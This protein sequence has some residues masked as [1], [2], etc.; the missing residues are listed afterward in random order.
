[1][2]KIIQTLVKKKKNSYKTNLGKSH[3]SFSIS[4]FLSRHYTKNMIQLDS[5]NKK[6]SLTFD[7]V[8]YTDRNIFLTGKA[9]TGKTTFL[10]NLAQ[11]TYKR[12]VIVA[13]TGV[14][15]INA[16]GVTIHSF[17]Q[18][19]F[20]PLIPETDG[21][22]IIAKP[23]DE[24]EARGLSARLQ[25]FRSEKIKLIKSIDLLVIDEIS[26]VRA[27]LLDAV[28][29]VLRR[30]RNKNKPFGGVQL[31]MI[32]DI[33]QLAPIAK[34]DEWDLLKDY[35]D[36]VYFFNSLALKKTSY[37]CIELD[38]IYRQQDT[39]FIDLLNKI[40]TNNVDSKCLDA[41]NS[42]YIPD[43]SPKDS[44][45][46][47]VLTTHHFQADL[48]NKKKHSQIKN[49]NHT[50]EA[51]IS[52][53][54]PEMSYPTKK[55]L[56]L[57]VGAQVMFVKNDPSSLKLFYNGKIGKIVDIDMDE[58]I[59]VKCGD[60]TIEVGPLDWQNCRY[61]LDEQTQEIKEEVIGEFTQYPLQLAWAITIH[62]SQGL[63]FEKVIIDANMAFAPG[64][65][66]VALSRCTSLEGL[67]LHSRLNNNAIKKDFSIENFSNAYH[68]Y[69]P[70]KTVLDRSK[71]DYELSI[72]KELFNFDSFN[73]YIRQLIKI[74][75]NNQNI[76][77]DGLATTLV[78]MKNKLE[79]EISVIGI[80]F[81]NQIFSLHKIEIPI[82]QNDILQE[83]IKK[84]S[85]YF[86]EK[87]DDILTVHKLHLIT[88]NSQVNASIIKI[89]NSYNEDLRVKKACIKICE[90]G[91]SVKN[92][93]HTKAI[94]LASTKKEQVSKRQKKQLVSSDY[95]SEL[96]QK[97]IYWRNCKAQDLGISPTK[98]ATP[99]SLVLIAD[100]LP[101]TKKELSEIA[102]FGKTRVA[103]HGDE[104]LAIVCDFLKIEP[105]KSENKEKTKEL[106]AS[107]AK[108]RQLYL[109]GLPIEEIAQTRN[110]SIST[111]EN[112]IAQIV[113]LGSLNARDIVPKKKFN[114]ISEYF[115]DV[116]DPRLGAAK[117]VLGDS[118][119]YFE[120]K[121]VL[122]QLLRENKMDENN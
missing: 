19:P 100:K 18:L 31:L 75:D 118:I 61:K 35:Y 110:V 33:H 116:Q 102:G 38:H 62:K 112:Y 44:E 67:V 24:T 21:K 25:Q 9:G 74:I 104:I 68:Q 93:L 81:Y 20:G 119:S 56:Q 37:I 28:D 95:E 50:F 64:Q 109:E 43:F 103:H 84:S 57:K 51:K 55:E 85:S 42:R 96:L 83:R 90:T 15:A 11:N 17:F 63:T 97:L 82:D 26:M 111:I 120:L 34:A 107:L 58:K 36:S 1:M 8:Q 87:I 16:G 101:K 66:Y 52:G 80:R 29:T 47:I 71:F 27:D 105:P 99:K 45:G 14:A 3:L 77:E 113:K 122:N 121:V 86:L 48:I 106:S 72:L 114:L 41:L 79:S 23:N 117:D 49:K 6:I 39:F 7:F 69:E 22:H 59:H 40:R 12:M 5:D 108:T 53:T 32:G 60:E 30:F 70:D 65:V 54:F 92:Y 115:L 4:V 98:I 10:R 76:F 46:Y 94:Q 73:L 88:D 89:M 13:P 78:E 2:C 91:F